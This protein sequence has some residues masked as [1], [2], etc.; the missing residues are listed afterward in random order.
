MKLIDVCRTLGRRIQVVLHVMDDEMESEKSLGM[1][2]VHDI[3][4]GCWNDYHNYDVIVIKPI[5]QFR[6][7]VIVVKE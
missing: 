2:E 5:D 6:L 1:H 7:K 4:K 3:M